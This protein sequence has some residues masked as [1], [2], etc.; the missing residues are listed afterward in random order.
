MRNTSAASL[1]GLAYGITAHTVKHVVLGLC[2][3]S[4]WPIDCMPRTE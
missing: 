4:K 1:P 2:M 3:T